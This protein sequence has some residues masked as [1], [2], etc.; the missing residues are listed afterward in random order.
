LAAAAAGLV[1]LIAAQAMG[2]DAG[3]SSLRGQLMALAIPAALGGL[4]YVACTTALG[5]DEVRLGW[6]MLLSRVRA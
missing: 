5:V 1:A 2:G 3:L 4:A 6:R